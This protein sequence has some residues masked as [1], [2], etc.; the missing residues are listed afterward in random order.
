MIFG[1]PETP[2]GKEPWGWRLEGHHLSLNFT[3]VGD[4]GRGRRTDVPRHQPRR[5]QDSG[6]RQGLR[7][8]GEEEDLARQLIKSFERRPSGKRRSSSDVAPKD[9]ISYN[10]SKGRARPAGRDLDARPRA[11]TR[12]SCSTRSSSFTPSGSAPSWPPNDLGKI[13]KAGVDKVGF[14]WAGGFERGQPH[15]YRIQGP[16]FLIEY[17]NTQNNANHVHSVW[18]DFEGDFGEDLL[19]KHYEAATAA[20]GHS[21]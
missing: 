10:R 2:G 13:L 14:G 8:L 18:R 5:G 7:V 6:R 15:Y 20:H 1:N 17:D 11:P 9:I 3:I 12:R 4:L 21:K 16:T 19:K